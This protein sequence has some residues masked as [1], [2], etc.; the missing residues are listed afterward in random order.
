MSS[1]FYWVN[2]MLTISQIKT[3]LC[4]PSKK[5]QHFP[6]ILD[7]QQAVPELGLIAVIDQ[8]QTLWIGLSTVIGDWQQFTI[9]DSLVVDDI[10]YC[11]DTGIEI[12]T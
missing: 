5:L 11:P 12:T 7:L 9:K 8:D 1:L 2:H 3:H 10:I 6:T 4:A